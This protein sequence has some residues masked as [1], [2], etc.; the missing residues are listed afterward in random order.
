MKTCSTCGEPKPKTEFNRNRSKKDGLQSKCR[1][2]SRDLA[3]AHFENNRE[4]YRNRNREYR[5]KLLEEVQKL[6]DRPCQDCGGSF[7]P[8]VMDF[9]HLDGETKVGSVGSLRKLGSLRQILQ[10]VSKCEVVCANCH[11]VRTHRWNE[12]M[13]GAHV[14]SKKR[15]R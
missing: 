1:D 14:K 6:K 13:V 8:Y 12:Q 7:P 2:C 10:E 11:R 9:D 5:R 4:H 3:K 15:Y